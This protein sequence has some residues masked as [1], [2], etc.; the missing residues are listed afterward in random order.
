MSDAFR[1]NT[2]ATVNIDVSSSSQRIQVYPERG[3][4]SVR[5]MN[6]GSATV[7]LS[8]GDETVAATTTAGFPVGPGVT[9]VL[10]FD[11]T[12]GGT[13]YVA[14]IAAGSTGKIYFTPGRGI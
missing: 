13:L 14:A 4:I 10:T 2:G 12:G 11:N 8:F 9:E 5:I 1:P 7:W 6:N 3:P